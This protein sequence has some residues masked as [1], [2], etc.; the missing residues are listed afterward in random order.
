MNITSLAV[1][2]RNS[3]SVAFIGRYA[4]LNVIVECVFFVE[5][6]LAVFAGVCAAGLFNCCFHPVIVVDMIQESCFC[7]EVFVAVAAV[8]QDFFAFVKLFA[9]LLM[10]CISYRIVECCVAGFAGV[11]RKSGNNAKQSRD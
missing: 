3:A 11:K 4:S 10:H 7:C 1:N 5:C 9:N 6:A 2:E 8:K